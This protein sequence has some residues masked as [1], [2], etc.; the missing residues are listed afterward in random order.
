MHPLPKSTQSVGGC[1]TQAGAWNGHAR[2]PFSHAPKGQC[3][4]PVIGG[5]QEEGLILEWL[6]IYCKPLGYAVEMLLC[7]V[8]APATGH[9]WA[10]TTPQ[11]DRAGGPFG[12]GVP[13]LGRRP[14]G[15]VWGPRNEKFLVF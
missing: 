1:D 15:P 8:S 3:A 10:T 11:A 12:K 9:G 5:R 7:S 4:F 6:R 13:D 2:S 14:A